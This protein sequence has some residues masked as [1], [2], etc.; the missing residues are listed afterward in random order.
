MAD[1]PATPPGGDP[2]PP[3][4]KRGRPTVL[5]PDLQKQYLRL[6]QIG[7]S[8]QEALLACGFDD[9]V[10]ARAR[11]ADPIFAERINRAASEGKAMLVECVFQARK[12]SWYAAA[13]ML[14]RRFWQEYAQ[15]RPDQF[16]ADDFADLAF[17]LTHAVH[18][19]LSR[20]VADPTVAGAFKADLGVEFRAVLED[21]K[22]AVKA[23]KR[24]RKGGG[25]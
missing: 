23:A 11:R 1:T 20:H 24:R 21:K 2:P 18:A 8:Q 22:A 5:T 3:K 19:V 9:K 10:I 25:K 4:R 7:M 14:E 6:L 12:R 16:T 17:Q 13:W 15:R